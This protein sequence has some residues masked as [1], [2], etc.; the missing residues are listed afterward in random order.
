MKEKDSD[1]ISLLEKA[2]SQQ[3]QAYPE[4]IGTVIKVGDGIC[5]VFGLTNAVL[6]R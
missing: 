1:L 3:P 2:L 6:G 4:E 5:K